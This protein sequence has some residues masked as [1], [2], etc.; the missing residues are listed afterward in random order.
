MRPSVV[1]CVVKKVRI[2][3]YFPLGPL[4]KHMLAWYT[5]HTRGILEKWNR[6][7]TNLLHIMFVF[8][9]Y[10]WMKRTAYLENLWSVWRF[11]S[12][13]FPLQPFLPRAICRMWGPKHPSVLHVPEDHFPE[14]KLPGHEVNHSL[15]FSTD[16]KNATSYTFIP[17][18][19]FH[20]ILQN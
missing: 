17:P 4:Q 18:Y 13:G 15:S 11:P 14:V 16:V 3:E 20:G 8:Q 10:D 9:R 6:G 5:A 19:V 7:T 2:R 1:F 12:C